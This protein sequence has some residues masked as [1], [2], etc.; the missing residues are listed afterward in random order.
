MQSNRK[1]THY[2]TKYFKPEIWESALR[3]RNEYSKFWTLLYYNLKISNTSSIFI[4]L[5]DS[6]LWGEDVLFTAVTGLGVFVARFPEVLGDGFIECAEETTL[7]MVG[8]GGGEMAGCVAVWGMLS[9]E[10]P[11]GK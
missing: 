4:F 2:L 9:L 1:C 8:F 10:V 7:E 6:S 3:S 11:M 5:G